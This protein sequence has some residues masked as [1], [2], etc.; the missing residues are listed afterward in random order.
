M[1]FR[2][3]TALH[4]LVLRPTARYSE[5]LDFVQMKPEPIGPVLDIIRARLDP[6]LGEPRLGDVAFLS[7]VPSLLRPGVA[8]D[9]SEAHALVEREL[10]TRL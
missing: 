3:G 5:D 2:G 8:Y 7:D 6:W 4:K 9:A 1:L 10:L